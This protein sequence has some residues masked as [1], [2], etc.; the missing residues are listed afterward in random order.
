[1][2][3]VQ[4]LENAVIICAKSSSH[5]TYMRSPDITLGHFICFHHGVHNALP[6]KSPVTQEIDREID[7]VQFITEAHVGGPHHNESKSSGNCSGLVGVVYLWCSI[8]IL[9]MAVI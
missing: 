5:C 7:G 6:V 3:L 4:F 1:M 8:N 2:L 9:M